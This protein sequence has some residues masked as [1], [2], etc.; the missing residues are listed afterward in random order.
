MDGMDGR[1]QVVVIGA[2]NRP[3]SVD[4]ALRRP[5]RFDRE[6][7]FPLPDTKARR[8]ILDIH[9]KKWNPP[10]DVSFK[11]QLAELTKGYGGAD[12]RALCTEAALNAVQGTY[13]QIYSSNEK[14][15][16]DPSKIKVTPKDFI[17]AMDNMVPSSQR[18]TTATSAPLEQ[19]VEPLLRDALN[20]IAKLLDEVLPQRKK[21]TALEEAQYEE[22]D[23]VHGFQQQTRQSTFERSRIHRPRLL[24]RGRQGMG[25]QH[26]GSALLNKFERLHVQSFDL[27]TILGDSASS[28]EATITRL[29][30]EV[31]RH[32]PSVIYIPNV[33]VWYH[34]IGASA[35]RL[36]NGLLQSLSPSD[37]V[38]V[39]A[40]VEEGFNADSLDDDVLKLFGYS[41]RNVYELQRPNE[42]RALLNLQVRSLLTSWSR[43]RGANSSMAFSTMCGPHHQ[44]FLLIQRIERSVDSKNWRLHLLNPQSSILCRRKS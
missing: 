14:L 30:T 43:A 36:F 37:Q 17:V 39:L 23:N 18:S 25:Q 9:T 33:D 27:A 11:D 12:I 32:K 44:N 26:I 10:P 4:P 8:A 31:K 42:V 29:F 3:D 41:K 24:I 28:P 6:F 1:G 13:P 21:L 34:T 19:S 38:L 40:I 20:D 35:A 2:T 15:I 7:Y 5:G 16:I 22:R